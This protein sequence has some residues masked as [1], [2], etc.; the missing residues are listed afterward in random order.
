MTTN[1]WL[2]AMLN[3][4][5]GSSPKIVTRREL[6]VVVLNSFNLGLFSLLAFQGIYRGGDPASWIILAAVPFLAIGIVLTCRKILSR[7]A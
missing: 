1:I 6:F 7:T 3:P 5:L 2:H 4:I